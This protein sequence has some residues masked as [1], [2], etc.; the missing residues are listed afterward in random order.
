MKG[1][2]TYS[3]DLPCPPRNPRVPN[4]RLVAW[5]SG[6]NHS[7][8]RS[9]RGDTHFSI[10]MHIITIILSLII[11]RTPLILH[12]PQISRFYVILA[13]LGP[14][15]NGIS[16]SGPPIFGERP[17]PR[18]FHPVEFTPIFVIFE[19]QNPRVE[20]QSLPQ[21]KYPITS[22]TSTHYITTTKSF[23]VISIY[24]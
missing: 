11:P 2:G 6:H 22:L 9:S 21:T 23:I 19:P 5:I 24:I 7:C 16:V 20:S 15:L 1:V 3:C 8:P 12:Q 14:N 13:I 10:P 4:T 17:Y 18:Q